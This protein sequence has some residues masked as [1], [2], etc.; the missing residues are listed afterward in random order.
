MPNEFLNRWV[1][2]ANEGKITAEQIDKEF[3]IF[4]EDMKWQLIKNKI[5]KDNNLEVQHDEV[6]AT[7]KK[8]RVSNSVNMAS[9]ICPMNK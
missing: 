6:V 2:F 9:I 5:A 4:E 7:R 1:T 8:S 3:P